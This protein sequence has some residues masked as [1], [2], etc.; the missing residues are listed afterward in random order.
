MGRLR[1]EAKYENERSCQETK[2]MVETMTRCTGHCCVAFPLPYSLEQIRAMVARETETIAEDIDTVAEMVYPIDWVPTSEE[3]AH[4]K[5]WGHYTYGC[6]HLQETGDCAIYERRPRMCRD[7][8]YG[9]RCPIEGCTHTGIG[10]PYPE[11]KE[12][13]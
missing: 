1:P 13:A 8:P 11:G 12:A 4:D 10:K 2:A 5:D 3:V 9:S 6:K 7:Y